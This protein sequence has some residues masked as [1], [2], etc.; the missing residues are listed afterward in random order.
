MPLRAVPVQYAH[1]LM[2]TRSLT[3][4]AYLPVLPHL[5]YELDCHVDS[6][7]MDASNINS[8]T[9]GIAHGTYETN[10]GGYS[11]GYG[12]ILNQALEVLQQDFV[13]PLARQSVRMNLCAGCDP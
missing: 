10:S 4:S 12:G 9:D 3:A 5:Q 11:E 13:R 2:S 1:M 6:P 7:S 8:I